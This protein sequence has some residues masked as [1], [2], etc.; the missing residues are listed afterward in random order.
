VRIVIEV[1]Y[2]LD[3]EEEDLI[4]DDDSDTVIPVVKRVRKVK[5]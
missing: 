3:G 5:S 1:V 4:E 2:D